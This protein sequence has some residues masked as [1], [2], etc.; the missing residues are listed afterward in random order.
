[1]TPTSVSRRAVIVNKT[2]ERQNKFVDTDFVRCLQG[3]LRIKVENDL[4]LQ[5][6]VFCFKISIVTPVEETCFVYSYAPE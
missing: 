6:W 5:S 4:S 1:M 3:I 2:S